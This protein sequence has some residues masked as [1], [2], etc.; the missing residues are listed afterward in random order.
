M[1]PCPC[2]SSLDY[3]KCCEPFI[4]GKAKAPNPE[5]LMRSRYTAYVK[6]AV[7]YIV[8]T[9]VNRGED[10]INVEETKRWSEQSEWKGLKI[11]KTEKGG[12]SDKEGS[13]EFIATYALDGLLQ[14]HHE[15]SGFKKV[16][17]EWLFDSGEVVPETVVRST[18]KV[19]RNDPCPCGS[20][21]KYK[22]CCAR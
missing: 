8:Q 20:G 21:K 14:N 4:S 22:Q 16:D 15:I 13:V 6:G 3:K 1:E 11:I 18:P 19:G 2:G 5:S 9:C 17:G 10:S 12:P 7:D